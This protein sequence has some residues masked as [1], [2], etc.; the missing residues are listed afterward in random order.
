V[1]GILRFSKKKAAMMPTVRTLRLM[2][3]SAMAESYYSKPFWAYAASPQTD[4]GK[5]HFATFDVQR[6]LEKGKKLLGSS[7]AQYDM[8]LSEMD[9]AERY[10]LG[11]G[12][13]CAM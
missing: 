3:K 2:H 4:A 10:G 6:V 1:N 12:V 8:D 5:L 9:P 13:R 11:S 7:G